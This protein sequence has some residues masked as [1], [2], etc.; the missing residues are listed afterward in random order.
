M[1]EP[2]GLNRLGVIDGEWR[3][4]DR[5]GLELE[6]AFAMSLDL[7]EASPDALERTS[8]VTVL[9]LPFRKTWSD[10]TIQLTT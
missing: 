7:T 8:L 6:F 1:G 4:S 5:G 9:T 2:E 10:A 3:D